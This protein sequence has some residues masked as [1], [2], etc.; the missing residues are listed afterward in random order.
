MQTPVHSS[1]SAIPRFALEGG[2][3]SSLGPLTALSAG[4]ILPARRLLRLASKSARVR[5]VPRSQLSGGSE[6]QPEAPKV[7]ERDE[8]YSK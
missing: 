4:G 6:G 3:P 1:F 7:G 5:R 2:A 8:A